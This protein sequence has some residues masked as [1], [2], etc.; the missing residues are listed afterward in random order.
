[1]TLLT[2]PAAVG[3]NQI[4]EPSSSNSN[5]GALY[6]RENVLAQTIEYS[7]DNS[8]W[9]T[10]QN[11]AGTGAITI[12]PDSLKPI[13]GNNAPGDFV[14]VRSITTNGRDLNIKAQGSIEVQSNVIISTQN[15]AFTLNAGVVSQGNSG[16]LSLDVEN[17]EGVVLSSGTP[18]ITIDSGAQ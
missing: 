9:S 11:I 15:T 10:L 13:F 12:S 7:T 16:N 5:N 14:I 17:P 8:T 1:R 6:L 3:S 4:F 2:G 18:H